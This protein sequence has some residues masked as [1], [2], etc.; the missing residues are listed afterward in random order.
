MSLPNYVS[1][2]QAE[3]ARHMVRI[4]SSADWQFTLIPIQPDGWCI[5]ACVSRAVGQTMAD[6]IIGLK[7]F[8]D[9]FVKS[10]SRKESVFVNKARFRTLW[11]R[12]NVEDD[13]TVQELWAGEDGDLLLLMIAEHLKNV[14][15]CIWN[16]IDGTLVNQPQVYG[17]NREKTVNLLQTNVIVPHYDLMEL[18]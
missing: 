15:I 18:K 2:V 6:L 11:K 3:E 10:R 7:G 12:L 5:F 14:Q 16:I 8:V 4:F 17:E 1:F 13:S 9:A